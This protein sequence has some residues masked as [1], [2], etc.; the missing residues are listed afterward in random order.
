MYNSPKST[1]KY[2][3][4]S[5]SEAAHHPTVR[6]SMQLANEEKISDQLNDDNGKDDKKP[7]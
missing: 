7:Q 3:L 2:E 5:S 6:G 4:G 1:S